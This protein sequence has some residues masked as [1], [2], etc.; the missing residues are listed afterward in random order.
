MTSKPDKARPRLLL[1]VEE[2][3][4]MLDVPVR[5]LYKWR[6]TGRGPASVLLPNRRIKYRAREVEEWLENLPTNIEQLPD[7]YRDRFL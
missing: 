1:S 6:Q 7:W 4:E 5:T 2:V 3:A